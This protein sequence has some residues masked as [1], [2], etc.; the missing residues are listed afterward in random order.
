MD[1][2]IAFIADDG[3]PAVISP[4]KEYLDLYGIEAIAVK[5]VPAG[6]PF[7]IMDAADVPD[8]PHEDWPLDPATL[9]D[10]IGGVENTFPS[11]GGEV[12]SEAPA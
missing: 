5:D 8:G 11:D 7:R 9:T 2:V 1:K 4:T 3:L 10:G 12:E 6:K